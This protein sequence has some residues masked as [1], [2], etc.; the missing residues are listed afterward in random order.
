[1]AS[2]TLPVGRGVL[3]G[4]AR[5]FLKRVV[6]LAGRSMAWI[7]GLAALGSVGH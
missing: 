4:R 5:C 6:G 2:E 1:M 3:P 7:R